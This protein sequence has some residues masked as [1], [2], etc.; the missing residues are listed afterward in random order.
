MTQA[1]CNRHTVLYNAHALDFSAFERK[2]Q[3]RKSLLTK[4]SDQEQKR[5]MCSRVPF[6]AA[7]STRYCFFT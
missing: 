7:A 1:I 6:D 3:S 4:N 5:E 2:R